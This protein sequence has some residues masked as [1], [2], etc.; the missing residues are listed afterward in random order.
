M[1]IAP[2]INARS[3]ETNARGVQPDAP[4]VYHLR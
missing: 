2:R 1:G 3:E 4:C